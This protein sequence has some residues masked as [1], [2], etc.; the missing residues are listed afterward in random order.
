M[1]KQTELF[2][3]S[4]ES[5]CSNCGAKFIAYYGTNEEVIDTVNVR[6]CEL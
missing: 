1:A 3:R 5:N 4:L 2:E 6:L